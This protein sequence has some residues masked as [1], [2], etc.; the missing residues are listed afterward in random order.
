MLRLGGANEEA[1]TYAKHWQCPICLQ[2][3][4]PKSQRPAMTRQ[5]AVYD[6]NDTVAADLLTV[7]DVD[8]KAHEVLSFVCWGSHYHVAVLLGQVERLG[9][10]HVPDVLGELGSCA[11]KVAVRSWRRV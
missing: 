8:G 3:A 2:S 9:D 5:Q 10:K 11:A 7:H 6:F 1:I 4:A